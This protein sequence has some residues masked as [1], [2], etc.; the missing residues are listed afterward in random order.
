MTEIAAEIL[1]IG[2]SAV[3]DLPTVTPEGDELQEPIEGVDVRIARTHADERGTLCEIF[4]RRWGFSD[5][6]VPFVY[7]ATVRPGRVKGWV[8]HQ[9]QEDR[10]FF[11]SGTARLSLYDS[12][13][14]SPTF[15]AAT[16]F[17][18]GSHQRALVSIPAG[19]YHAVRN[20]GNDEV[21]FMNLP[22]RPYD[23]ENPDKYRLP[24]DTDLIPVEP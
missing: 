19:V 8:V 9:R 10:L 23:H 17:H 20:V 13:V 2:G 14:D 1:G 4:D 16:V 12:R 11:S 15:G 7:V 5:A 18:F 22:T 21:V 6:D 24:A 3:K